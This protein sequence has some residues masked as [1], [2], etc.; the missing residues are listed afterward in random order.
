MIVKQENNRPKVGKSTILIFAGPSGGH[1]FPAKA[2]AEALRE[3]YPQ[4]SLYLITGQRA[5][6][7]DSELK[8]GPFDQIRYSLDFPFPRKLSWAVFTFFFRFIRTFWECRD[9]IRKLRPAL[10]AGFGS[11]VCVPGILE[12][13]RK[14]IPVLLHEQNKVAGMATRALAHFSDCLALSFQDTE[15]EHLKGVRTTAVT[16]LPVRRNLID[17]ALQKTAARP[18]GRFTLLIMGGSQGAHHLNQVVLNGIEKMSPEEREKFAVI[19]ITGK[20]DFEWVSAE[21]KKLKIEHQTHPF[22]DKMH[23]LFG[24]ADFAITRAGANTLFELALFSIPAVVIPY[25]HAEAHQKENALYFS[26]RNAVILRD[27]KDF[28]TDFFLSQ[29]RYF[30]NHPAHL[31]LFKR[32]AIRLSMPDAAERLADIAQELLEPQQF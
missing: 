13:A 18:A 27:Q 26:R 24:Q 7:F 3:R 31:D 25:P 16:G 14:R 12:S 5:K 30:Y 10:C 29:V 4:S 1:L 19:H 21:Y 2:F 17:F 20:P 22:F 32:A 6:A 11:Y 28:D 23:L 8:N 15:P 9:L